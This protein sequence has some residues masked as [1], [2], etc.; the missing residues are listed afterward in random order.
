MRRVIAMLLCLLLLASSGCLSKG[1]VSEY[2]FVLCIGFE[3]GDTF[4]YRIV[5]LIAM[6]KAG[7]EDGATLSTSVCAA[8]ARTLYEAVETLN[9]GLPLRLRFSRTSLLL[10]AESL[11]EDGEIDRLM[12]FSLGALDIHSNV[13]VMATRGRMQELFEA[14]QSDADPSFSKTMKNI[15]TLST[16][17]GT[18]ID[19]RCRAVWEALGSAPLDLVLPLIGKDKPEPQPDGVGAEPYPKQAG[20]LVQQAGN[21]VSVIGCAVFDGSRMAGTLSGLHTR[22]CAMARGVFSE[23]DL[24][25][26]HPEHGTISVHLRAKRSPKVTLDGDAASVRIQLEAVPLYPLS[27]LEADAALGAWLETELCRMLGN[28]FETLKAWNADAIGFGRT[29]AM[30][31]PFRATE[32]W[33]ERYP[34]LSAQFDVS[35]TVLQAGGAA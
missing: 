4:A 35:V 14:M 6:P 32:D 28:L 7:E 8:E 5:L 30:R 22:L 24:T 25:L 19:A 16:R 9:A 29:D 3:R 18:V 13:R 1:D 15:E 11:L 12:D 34:S 10:I 2:A 23:G 31:N 27:E 26:Y 20:A 33:K 17:S 21:G